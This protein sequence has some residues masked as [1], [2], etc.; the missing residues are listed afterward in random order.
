MPI[1][2]QN[3]Y[4]CIPIQKMNTCLT[5][6]IYKL[7]LI[8]VSHWLMLTMPVILI[9]YNANNLSVR[10]LFMIQAAYSLTIV[11]FELPSGYLADR[12]GRKKTIIAGALLN[13]G[14]YL[15][16]SVSY[17][18]EGFLVAQLM[19]GIGMSFMSGSDTA[20]LYDTLASMGQQNR[21]LKIEGRM[22]SV[23]NFAEAAAGIAA[24]FLL[25]VSPRFPFICQAFVALI[26]VPAAFLLIEP[27]LPAHLNKPGPR[28]LLNTLKNALFVHP[29]LRRNLFLSSV[30]GASTLTMAWFV[31]PFFQKTG[32]PET[33]Y[34]ILWTVLNA[35]VGLTALMAYRI[36]RR[37]GEK[38]SVRLVV[39]FTTA[40]YLS[41]AA[42]Q[43][44]WAILFILMFY[45]V[46]GIATPVL[47][48]Y[49]NKHLTAD[50][51]A[52][53]LSLR[54]LLIRGIFAILGPLWGWAT[55]HI[56]LQSALIMAGI[57]YLIFALPFLGL[58]IAGL[59]GRKKTI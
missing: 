1:R 18:F 48:D 54:S 36:E 53:V 22:T 49:L 52:S 46:R 51:R 6:N 3:L 15:M 24:G 2:E 58:R 42:F 11:L 47:K 33:L 37:L 39:A 12:W 20:M 55:D 23:G 8:K 25:L 32:V 29:D 28:E 35:S 5:S 30:L 57:S 13:F 40:G 31:Q 19:L 26:A 17:G 9:F 14:G 21:Y 50:T 43:S 38:Q 7:Y 59:H 27:P 56:S 41:L 34:G 45:L 44:A 4:F 16:Y 10:H